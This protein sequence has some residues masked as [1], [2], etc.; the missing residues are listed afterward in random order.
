MI[1]K[2]ERIKELTAL[3][4][5]YRN[6]YYNLAKPSVSDSDYDKLFGELECLEINTGFVLS[7]SPTQTVGYDVVS[8]LQKRTHPTPL[9]SLDKTKSINDLIKWAGDKYTI[10]MLKADGLTVELDYNN[11]VLT[12]G[13]T[14]G[15]GEVGEV[16]SH[17]VTAF[18]NVPKSIPFKGKL[19]LSGEAI[20][21]IDD[22]EQ[23][24]SS[25]SADDKY[26]T[27]RNLVSGSVRQLDSKICA[28]RNVH[29]Y[30]FNIL[31]CDTLTD[32]K[33][34]NLNWLG[35]QGFT[36]IP[37]IWDNEFKESNIEYLKDWAKDLN[38]PID[39][40]V[41]SFNSIKYSNSLGETSHH[42]LHSIAYKFEDETEESVLR[43]VEWNTTRT[44]QINPTAIFDTVILD[45]TEVSRAS[46]FN[47]TFIRDMGLDIG[48]RIKVSKR[49]LIIPYIEENLDKDL[50]SLKFPR[51]CSTCGKET[52]IRN[53]GT[54]EFLFCTNEHCQAKLLDKFVHFVSRNAM[55]IDGFSEATIQ[56][57]VDA[58]LLQSF[59]NIYQLHM[60]KGTIVNM[61]G[62]GVKSYNKLIESIEKSKT[63]KLE[64]FIYA[65][66]IPNV[67]IGSAKIL[68][69]QFKGDWR[70]FEKAL[71]SAFDFSQLQDFGDITKDSLHDWY[72]NCNERDMWINLISIMNFVKEEKKESNVVDSPFNNT[73]VYATG[74]FANYKKEEIQK[75]LESLGAEFASGYAKSL[76]YLIVGSIKGSSKE[77]KAKKD[78]IKILTEDEFNKM[79]GK[80]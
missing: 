70:E 45:N 68:S 21:H 43:E 39:G 20:I 59:S 12:G 60:H 28:E 76:D 73:K 47:L 77:D 37:S 8:K 33:Q 54:A 27:P 1:N 9:R 5:T 63:V 62:M 7:N 42:P 3:L 55:N 46:L 57:F 74:T 15:N 71:T 29:F 66:G 6:E 13:Y 56:K 10:F 58:D 14:R 26:K 32:S 4:N 38:L 61:E 44:G 24:N 2:I 72:N 16:I 19:R 53:T 48:N 67:G 34:T 17:N 69:K 31:E 78:D 22:F 80:A 79:I 36:A 25:L 51:F 64:N 40:L 41:L 23:I 35:T 49:N 30:A 65:L 18:K 11:G 52:K 50:S 75:L